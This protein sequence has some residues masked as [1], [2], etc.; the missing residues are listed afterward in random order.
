VVALHVA[1]GG[2]C[3]THTDCESHNLSGAVCIAPSQGSLPE[4]DRERFD[5]H[6]ESCAGCRRYLDQ[7]RTTIRVVGTLTEDDLGPGAKDRLLQI[8][9]EWKPLASTLDAS[10]IVQRSAGRGRSGPVIPPET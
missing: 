9:C 7:M 8:F 1:L 6:L 10:W 3:N 2:C 4:A 5:A